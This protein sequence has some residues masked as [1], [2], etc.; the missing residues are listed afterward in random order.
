MDKKKETIEQKI[1]FNKQQR[2]QSLNTHDRSPSQ[3]YVRSLSLN[4][5][6]YNLPYRYRLPIQEN[7]VFP[8]MDITSVIKYDK[9]KEIWKKELDDF[10]LNDV[11]PHIL[12]RNQIHGKVK[13][14]PDIMKNRPK[15]NKYDGDF[16]YDAQEDHFYDAYDINYHMKIAKMIAFKWKID[17]VL[18][19]GFILWWGLL[20]VSITDISRNNYRCL[21]SEYI[22]SM[23]QIFM[24][25]I[26]YKYH[27]VIDDT[28]LEDHI[29]MDNLL[30]SEEQIYVDGI[31]GNDEQDPKKLENRKKTIII[32]LSSFIALVF[33]SDE[34]FRLA[35]EIPVSE[36]IKF[37]KKDN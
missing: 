13:G 3:Q 31:M 11:N 37:F 16:F 27:S 33:I 10:I 22:I 25:M 18:F 15:F 35:A 30:K 21:D 24:V 32:V 28:V 1:E 5:N 9:K 12:S 29:L 6:R 23:K 14:I 7:T 8:R 17:Y 26:R 2:S 36:I 19:K 4:D 20:P 34:A